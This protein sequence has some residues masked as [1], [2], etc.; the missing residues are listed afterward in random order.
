MNATNIY[1]PSS[2][3]AA[4]Y[5]QILQNKIQEG[6]RSAMHT[7][8]RVMSEAPTDQIVSTR[9]VDFDASNDGLVVVTEQG[10]FRPSDYAVGQIAARAAVPTDYLRGLTSHD[11]KPWQHGLAAEVL[12]QHYRNR[13][14]ERVLARSVGRQMRGWL[15]DRFRRIDA[16][17]LLETLTGALQTMGAV[18]YFGTATETRVALKALHPEIIEPVPGEFLVLGLE[19]SNSDYGNGPHRLSQFALRV[20]CLNGMTRES[21]LREVHIGGRLSA[22]I[23]YSDR[24]YNLDTQASVSALKDTVK[25][26]LGPAARD[27]LVNEIRKANDK[28]YSIGALKTATKA[29]SAKTQKAIVDAFESNDV[30]NL[31]A[32]PTAWR[33]SNAIS[34]IAKTADDETKLDLERL[35]GKI[36]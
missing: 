27:K 12:R 1:Q 30:I 8:E 19:W 10:N 35:A 34:W 6:T 21:V 20:A 28:E 5:Q 13:P 26:V 11:S 25:G 16:R 14:A 36:V 17:P 3:E 23:L 33:A 22:D 7:I 15:S 32:G 29:L 4:R 24:T 2:N 9:S 31:P 18:P